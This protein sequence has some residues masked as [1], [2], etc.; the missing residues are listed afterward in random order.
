MV[1]IILFLTMA[2]F[3]FFNLV[4]SYFYPFLSLNFFTL[5]LFCRWIYLIIILMLHIS[6]LYPFVFPFFSTFFLYYF[7]SSLS[8]FIIKLSLYLLFLSHY[9]FTSASS[10]SSLSSSST[11]LS[12]QTSIGFALRVGSN[13]K[14]FKSGGYVWRAV[15]R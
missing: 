9:L 14:T 15:G 3:F 6:H 11:S 1:T 5:L 7:H 10:S 2:I 12:S 8:R 4:D 13:Y